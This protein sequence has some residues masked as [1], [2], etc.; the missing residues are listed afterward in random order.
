MTLTTYWTTNT[1]LNHHYTPSHNTTYT[2]SL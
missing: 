2:R 1:P